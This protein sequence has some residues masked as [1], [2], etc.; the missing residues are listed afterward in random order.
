M[1]HDSKTKLR[2]VLLDAHAILHRA[3]HALPDFSSSKGEPT[4][5]LYGLSSMLIKIIADLKPD[6]MAA[7]YDLP[8]ATF[9]HEAYKEYKAGRAKADPELVS[10]IK[11][12]RDIFE[13]F[14]IP[15]Y[16][17]E[18]FEAD[19]ILGTIVELVKGQRSKVKGFDLD[20]IIASGDMDTLQLVD[21]KKVR[22]YTLKKG[23]A[24]TILYDEDSVIKRFGFP[25]KLLPDYK[26]L[27]GDPSDNIIG[28]K[29]VGE[30]TGGILVSRFGTIEELYGKLKKSDN[31]FKAAGITDRVIA[32]LKANE[33]EAE[34]SKMLA[35]IR[36]DAP[37]DF[38]LPEKPW[39]QS[40]DMGK[41]IKLFSEL[42]FRTLGARLTQALVGKS[43]EKNQESGIK[44]YEREKEGQQKEGK[45]AKGEVANAADGGLFTNIANTIPAPDP[46]SL[47]E[48]AIALWLINSNI[49]NPTLE[50]ILNFSGAKNFAEARTAVFKRLAELKLTAVFETIEKPLIPVVRGMKERGIGVDAAQLKKLSKEYHHTLA[51]L[52]KKIWKLAGEEF[53]VSSPKQ[54][55]V[56]LFEKLGLKAKNQKKTGTGLLSTK[57]SEL[58][59]LREANPII[60]LI[61]E[62]R[63]LAK[64][65]GTYIDPVALADSHGAGA[66]PWAIDERG[67]L[68]ATFLQAGTTTG[69][70]GCENPNLQNI[71]NKTELGRKIRRAFAAAPG[72]SLVAFDYSQ[73]ELRIAAFLSGDRKLIEIFKQGADVHTAVASEVF[74]VPGD[75][76]HPEMRRKAKVINFGVMYGM[77][78]NAL[79][80]NLGGD[81][82][83]GS[84]QASREEA[85]KFYNDYFAKFSGLARYLEAVKAEARRRGFTETFFGRRRYFLGITS[86]LP[87]IRASA[88]RQAA[89]API[90]GTEADIIKL[91]MINVDRFIEKSGLRGKAYLLLQVHDELVYEI[92]AGLVK[93][94]APE[95]K[96][97]MEN[98][99]PPKD[100]KG[101][102]IAVDASVGK[103]W[104]SMLRLAD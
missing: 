70:M 62:Y 1:I 67:R 41:V 44:N 80:A 57:E 93:K 69:R 48:T 43:Q 31:S 64:L 81:P 20:I 38:A 87:F 101:V 59:K 61:L 97:I 85:Q 47:A 17:K 40:L 78:V 2:L 90:Q 42:E 29:G 66:I 94:T 60:N 14:T 37:I 35:L 39:R 53:N 100:I 71:P 82:S 36:R 51:G 77:G 23:I 45:G 91:A 63:E 46:E 7:A 68:H 27:R 21:D 8:K 12:S 96:K 25:P 79:R 33:E 30:K 88:E 75:K 49:T 16:D 28:V 86:K 50:D 58:E 72:F 84:G 24:D 32:L 92:E 65:L 74:G 15:I 102:P 104:G 95:I 83:A 18:G 99:L 22:V 26:G 19:D 76:V 5:A 13:A 11:R 89:N 73:I 103:N 10:Q 6:Y 3:Y 54:L 55:A 9:R 52:Q 4:G 34:F 98:V 56:V